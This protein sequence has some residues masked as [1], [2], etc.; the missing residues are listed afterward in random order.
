M[1]WLPGITD[2]M[3][4]ILSKLWEMVR[5]RQGWH[6][7]VHAVT[8]HWTEQQQRIWITK[9]QLGKPMLPAGLDT[10]LFIPTGQA[11]RSN[12]KQSATHVHLL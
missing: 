5:D 3:D 6:A 1:R 12:Q 7:A 11:T 8:K 10:L 9:Q 2:S 4:M